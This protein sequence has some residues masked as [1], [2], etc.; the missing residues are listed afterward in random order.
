MGIYIKQYVKY[1]EI[2]EI[3]N[4]NFYGGVKLIN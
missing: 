1:K 4:I 2:A 3:W